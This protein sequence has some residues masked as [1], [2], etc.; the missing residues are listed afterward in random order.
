MY[1]HVSFVKCGFVIIIILITTIIIIIIE[2]NIL[3]TRGSL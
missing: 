3:L 2:L 1:V